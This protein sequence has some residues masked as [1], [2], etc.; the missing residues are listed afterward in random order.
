MTDFDIYKEMLFKQLGDLITEEEKITMST[1][2]ESFFMDY[3]VKVMSAETIKDE[4]E[5]KK[6][7]KDLKKEFYIYRQ[8][9]NNTNLTNDDVRG[10]TDLKV[11]ADW[12]LLD[13]EY[14]TKLG[15][16]E[17]MFFK[18]EASEKPKDPL[19]KIPDDHPLKK[20]KV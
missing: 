15:N 7:K 11:I 14:T 17:Y 18:P 16:K 4:Q 3:S 19:A 2:L 5:K 13:I 8:F 10:R 12:I 6:T 9:V 20:L 1:I